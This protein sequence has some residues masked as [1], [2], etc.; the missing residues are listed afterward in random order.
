MP[1][2]QQLILTKYGLAWISESIRWGVV[3]CVNGTLAA[4]RVEAAQF[5]ESYDEALCVGRGEGR[6]VVPSRGE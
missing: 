2:P 6:Y 5:V 4:C 1:V 3:D